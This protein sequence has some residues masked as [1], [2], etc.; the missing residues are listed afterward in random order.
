MQHKTTI[1]WHAWTHHCTAAVH[2]GRDEAQTCMQHQSIGGNTVKRFFWTANVQQRP[3]ILF[4]IS[5]GRSWSKSAYI[6]LVLVSLALLP[7]PAEMARVRHPLQR[8]HTQRLHV[9]IIHRVLHWE[10]TA[11]AQPRPRLNLTLSWVLPSNLHS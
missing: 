1:V 8:T 5:S 4:I 2:M 9:H 6:S 10:N 7:Q 3:V 11:A